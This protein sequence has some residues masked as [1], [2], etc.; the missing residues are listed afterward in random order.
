M[1]NLK[2]ISRVSTWTCF[3]RYSKNELSILFSF[4]VWF[5]CV[6]VIRCCLYKNSFLNIINI[7]MPQY[8]LY[9]K[10]NIS[11]LHNISN[12]TVRSAGGTNFVLDAW[13]LYVVLNAS[14]FTCCTSRRLTITWRPIGIPPVVWTGWLPINHETDGSGLPKIS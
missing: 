9:N 2:I 1:E 6:Y 5:Y 4:A 14:R 7:M 11:N 10:E 12:R 13:H 8:I 3:K